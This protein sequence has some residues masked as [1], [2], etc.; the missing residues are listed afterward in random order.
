MYMCTS[1]SK[2]HSKRS[3]C[4][5]PANLSPNPRRHA[6]P[7]HFAGQGNYK[8]KEARNRLLQKSDLFRKD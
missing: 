4:W 7:M 8:R 6:L 5:E 1:L 3:R 2:R